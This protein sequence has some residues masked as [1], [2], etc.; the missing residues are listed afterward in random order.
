M[1]IS[2]GQR[3]EYT[4][5][6]SMPRREEKGIL[7]VNHRNGVLS[8]A[9]LAN[10]QPVHCQT[11]M[12]DSTDISLPARLQDFKARLDSAMH[13]SPIPGAAVAL[14]SKDSILF[15][16]VSGFADKAGK[17]PV[18]ENTHFCIGSCTKSFTG[19]PC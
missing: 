8:L 10:A 16:W 7:E 14:V 6:P 2:E 19:L 3:N 18:T 9:W 4:N 11:A 5:P 1:P 17:I 15:I 13:A 12:S